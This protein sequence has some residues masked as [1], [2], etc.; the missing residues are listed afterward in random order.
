M[1]EDSP[2][3]DE[4][5][6]VK[7]HALRLGLDLS[8]L[9]DQPKEARCQASLKPALPN[10]RQAATSL[11]ASWFALCGCPAA[12]PMEPTVYDL[13]VAIPSQVIGGRVAI[14]LRTYRE[15][16]VGSAAGLIAPSPH[17]A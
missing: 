9:T 5:I 14:L 8:Y 11:A 4:R 12:I 2:N 17:A 1:S 7:A 16:I 10:L 15:Y 13:L 6:R 3:G